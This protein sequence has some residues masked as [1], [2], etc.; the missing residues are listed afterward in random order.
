[1]GVVYR[2]TYE[3]FIAKSWLK[4]NDS[5]RGLDHIARAHKLMAE[6]GELW[7]ESESPGSRASCAG[8]RMGRRPKRAR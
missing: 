1:M 2:P 3:A 4:L 7:N 6:S 5:A 8:C